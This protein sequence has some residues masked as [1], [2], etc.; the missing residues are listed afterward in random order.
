MPAST[1]PPDLTR[2]RAALAAYDVID[3]EVTDDMTRRAL[4]LSSDRERV[5]AAQLQVSLRRAL[6]H[7]EFERALKNSV[8]SAVRPLPRSAERVLFGAASRGVLSLKG[9]P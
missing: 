8:T 3:R 7:P 1:T 9:A 6:L 5:L 4:R 2:T